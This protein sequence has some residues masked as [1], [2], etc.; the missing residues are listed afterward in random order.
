MLRSSLC[1]ERL[2]SCR[3]VNMS[4]TRIFPS[5]RHT[6]RLPLSFKNISTS[7]FSSTRPVSVFLDN[8]EYQ[9]EREQKNEANPF[10]RTAQ[11]T[12][13]KCSTCF[14]TIYESTSQSCV[15][16]SL[17]AKYSRCFSVSLRFR[18]HA[19]DRWATLTGTFNINK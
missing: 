7:I 17:E 10:L 11:R 1:R 12:I 2:N 19:L 9:C 8:N 4:L 14:Y 13:L 16:R 6:Q 15:A 3:V 5:S 18:V